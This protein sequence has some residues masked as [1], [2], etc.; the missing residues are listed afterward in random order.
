MLPEPPQGAYDVVVR[1]NGDEITRYRGAPTAADANLPH[2]GYDLLYEVRRPAGE[3]NK[4]WYV[5]PIPV[6]LIAPGARVAVEVALEGRESD[7]SLVIFGDYPPDAAT[8]IGPSLRSPRN[9]A[10]TSIS[11]YLVDGDSRLRR[12]MP[13]SRFHDGVGWTERDL[14]FDAGRQQGRYRIVLVLTYESGVVIL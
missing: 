7:G 14:A 10:D 4:A 5:I 12:R 9:N 8:D 2:D 13:H 1:V 6:A 3:A 11:K